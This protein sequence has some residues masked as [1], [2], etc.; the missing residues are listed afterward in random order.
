MKNK[1]ISSGAACWL[2]CLASVAGFQSSSSAQCT[3]NFPV[4]GSGAFIDNTA[5]VVVDTV[6]GPTLFSDTVTPGPNNTTVPAGTYPGWCIDTTDPIDATSGGALN[7]N[8]TYSVVMFSTCDLAGTLDTDLQNYYPKSLANF[9]QAQWDEINYVINNES[10]SYLAIQY[11]IWNII[12]ETLPAGWPALSPADQTAY[13][14]MLAAAAK[15]TTYQPG[16]GNKI[17]IVLAVPGATGGRVQLT[18]IEV[19]V[20]Q[21]QTVC[22][23][24]PSQGCGWWGGS[25]WCNGQ[26]SCNPGKPCTVSCHNA[27]VT[28]NCSSGHSYTYSV[29]DCDVNF[30]QQCS[31]A[32]S[33]FQNGKWC[34]TVP[35]CGDSQIFLSGCG[36][37]WQNDFNNCKSVCWTGTF[38][39]STPGVSCQWHCG[40][41]C[42]NCD[43]SNCNTVQPKPCAQNWCGWNNNNDC[44]GTPENYKSYCANGNNNGWNNGWNCNGWNNSYCGNWSNPGYCRW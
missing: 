3:F 22:C 34:T 28:F 27:C 4:N 17:A 41:S 13:N 36:I 20:P 25:V 6:Y 15:N 12:G 24:P 23:P 35:C 26:I 29:P 19:P 16:P 40:S 21:P 11:A 14:N 39:C 44:A 37:P 38:T 5:T 42:Y 9:S 2:F 1:F 43:L 18:I 8:Q 10:G 33:C 32:S 30:S 7:N 31:T